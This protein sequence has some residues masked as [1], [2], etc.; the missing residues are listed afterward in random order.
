MAQNNALNNATSA[1]TVN[2]AYTLP[3][4]DGNADEVLT[5]DG[6]GG[7]SWQSSIGES[8]LIHLSTLTANNSA[9]IDFT[10]LITVSYNTYVIYLNNVV[11][12]TNAVN[13]SM[14][15]SVDNGT[16]WK[17]TNYVGGFFLV[18]ITAAASG[19]ATST[20]DFRMCSA[21]QNTVPG[22]SGRIDLLGPMTGAYPVITG[23]G[24]YAPGNTNHEYLNLYGAYTTWT[25]VNA[26]RFIM[27]SGNITSGIFTLYAM[28]I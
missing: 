12:A 26:I 17:S 19:V 16:S 11:C 15:I 23:R 5:T 18:D 28:A 10:S 21:L 8:G 6:A 3:T 4:V 9:S 20:T 1:F 27:S 25:S 14:L 7:V 22:F 24:H 2:S 13:F